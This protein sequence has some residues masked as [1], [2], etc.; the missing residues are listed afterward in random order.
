MK[1]IEEIVYDFLKKKRTEHQLYLDVIEL[2][3]EQNN[4]ITKINNSA[5]YGILANLE[6]SI[7]NA[8]HE[9]RRSKDISYISEQRAILYKNSTLMD[10]DNQN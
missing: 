1:K 8:G 3:K 9:E 4:N 7:N 5:F 10:M 2:V 6:N